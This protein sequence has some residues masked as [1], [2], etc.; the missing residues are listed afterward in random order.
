MVLGFSDY[1]IWKTTDPRD[2]EPEW[3]D[4]PWLCEHDNDQGDCDECALDQSFD[5]WYDD[6]PPIE[7]YLGE[8]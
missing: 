8:H 4:E 7:S 1:D 3:E 6:P 5:D 2:Y